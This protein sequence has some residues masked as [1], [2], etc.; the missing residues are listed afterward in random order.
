[1]IKLIIFDL[2]GVLVDTEDIH[3]RCLINAINDI[4]GL[5]TSKLI[6]FIKKDGTTTNHKLEILKQEFNLTKDEIILIDNRKQLN[7]I[8]CF[9]SKIPTSPN[10]YNMLNLLKKDYK[11]ALASNSRKENVMCIVNVL[12]IKDFFTTI[13]TNSDIIK[14]KPDPEIFLMAIQKEEVL[15]AETLI[16]EDTESGKY[17]ATESGAFLLPVGNIADVTLENIINAINPINT[18]YSRSYGRNGI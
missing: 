18:E 9:H 12:K 8:N 3:Y 1:M 7:T 2:D 11:L 14:C 13:L 4:T 6:P 15:P 16:L 10:L 5:P 17:A